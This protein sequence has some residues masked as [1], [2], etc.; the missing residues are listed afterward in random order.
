M[1]I[2]Y[3]RAKNIKMEVY[4]KFRHINFSFEHNK[5]QGGYTCCVDNI[6]TKEN[7]NGHGLIE[8]IGNH[9]EG[10]SVKE[11][12]NF[13]FNQLFPSGM[14]NDQVVGVMIDNIKNIV[15]FPRG[16]GLVFPNLKYFQVRR[17]SLKMIKK[18]DFLDLGNLRGLWLPENQLVSLPNDIFTN[19][20]G[21]RHLCFYKNH[22][23]YIGQDILKPLKQLE[24]ANFSDNT[25]ININYDKEK[26][27]SMLERLKQA[28]A[29]DCQP[30]VPSMMRDR[31][32]EL[33]NRVLSLEG[34]IRSLK[35]ENQLLAAKVSLIAPLE[36]RIN[37]LHEQ[38]N[39]LQ[40]LLN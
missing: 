34:E 2:K 9:A 8:I 30:P 7:S 28:I 5:N 17:S 22:L 23:K 13:N 40:A 10:K 33:E 24:R 15:Y 11:N 29:N 1:F 37:S 31:S 6:V 25:C 32:H 18:E 14:N 39:H 38:M 12:Y 35:A 27:P 21:L 4:C 26:D 16:F 19:V 20:Q 36:L 3:F